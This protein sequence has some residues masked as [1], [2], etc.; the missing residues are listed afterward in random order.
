M[1]SRIF[2]LL[3][4]VLILSSCSS[5]L[6]RDVPECDGGVANSIVMQIQS[7]AGAAYVPCV[8]ALEAGWDFNHVDPRSGLATFSID[9]DRLGDPFITI[10]T[11]AVCDSS[12][13]RPA[14]TDEPPIEL[15]MD[16][17]EDFTVEIVVVPEGPTEA[18]L[19]AAESIV[20]ESFGLHLRDRT[21][22]A[23]IDATAGSTRDRIAVAHASGAHVITISI[24]G[25]EEG[26]VSLLLAGDE[27]ERAGGRLSHALDE[28]EEQVEK[29]TYRGSWFYLFEGGCTEYRFDAE[30]L[31]VET[32]AG[33]IR[34]S[35]S[36]VDANMIKDM[37]RQAGYDLP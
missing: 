8:S 6:G 22:N 17:V 27:E 28:I 30:G 4:L 21:V 11:T 26:T 2:L 7:V 33:D 23:H 13:A 29:P 37:A 24:R 3:P 15:Y 18:T 25:A 19:A 36:F 10:R 1:R 20:F 12:G 31:G 16:V 35:L 34:R 14:A 9:S 32:V 5:Q